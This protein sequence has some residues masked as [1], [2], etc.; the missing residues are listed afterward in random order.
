MA[1]PYLFGGGERLFEPGL[2]C[3]DLLLMGSPTLAGALILHC[4]RELGT[5]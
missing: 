4:R 5:G 2:S 3:L 1:T